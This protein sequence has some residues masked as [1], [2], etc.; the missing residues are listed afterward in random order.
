MDLERLAWEFADVFDELDHAQINE[1]LARNVPFETL[2]FFTEY[3]EKYSPNGIT[4]S[5]ETR[6][7]LPNLM[8]IGYLLRLV[9]DRVQ[10]TIR[11]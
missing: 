5:D 1:V 8:L 9:E 7:S 10:P 11:H 2:Q 3:A 6:A 4:L